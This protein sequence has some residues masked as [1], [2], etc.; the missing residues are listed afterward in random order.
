VTSKV[1]FLGIDGMDTIVVQRMLG[2]MPN[3]ADLMQRGS[4]VNLRS[5]FPPDSD[6]AWA[7]IFTGLNPA[8]HGVVRFVDPLEKVQ[9]IQTR[10]VDNS[11]L[12]GRTF[13]DAAC[14]AGM[15]VCVLFPHLG[16]PPWKVNGV[17]MARSPVADD[18]QVYPEGLLTAHPEMLAAHSP[19]GFPGRR[20]GQI[21]RFVAELRQVALQD[22]D[23]GVELLREEEWDLFFIYWSTLDAVQ[24]YFW[25][26]YDEDAPGFQKNGRF[27]DVIPS[28]YGFFDE[29]IG[30]FLDEASDDTAI[31]VLSDHGHGMRPSRLFNVN[32]LLSR[33]GFLAPADRG[34]RP[35]VR[36][37]ERLKQTLVEVVSQHRLGRFAGAALR[38]FPR[39]IRPFTRPAWIDWGRTIAYATD[40]SGIK[41]YS[42]GGIHVRKDGMSGAAYESMRDRIIDLLREVCVTEDDE[43]LLRFIVRR[44]ELCEGPHLG[45]YPDILLELK[46]GLGVGHSIGDGLFGRSPVSTL[47]PGSHRG[48]TPIFLIRAPGKGSA[49]QR[50]VSMMD[51]APTVLDLLELDPVEAFD[52]ETIFRSSSRS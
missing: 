20:L 43:P 28:F 25:D 3:L 26:E 27:R 38:T 14:E 30:R 9:K 15:R 10:L 17:M 7:S 29:V 19:R 35:W 4:T 37:A 2:A 1:L 34:Q 33:N 22:A 41:A 13:W 16:Y 50:T 31:I 18:V 32:E 21:Q 51:V 23:L 40:M 12:R 42:Y 8:R 52:G 36:A 45:A 46:Y 5:T 47:M 39:A 24:H 49:T 44:E 6:T 48:E 11:S